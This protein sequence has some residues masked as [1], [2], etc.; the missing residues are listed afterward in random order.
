MFL[1]VHMLKRKILFQG[2][3]KKNQV[4]DT[5]GFVSMVPIVYF[6]PEAAASCCF[7]SLG[8][9]D[10]EIFINTRPHFNFLFWLLS[11]ANRFILE[12]NPQ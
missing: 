6:F 9:Q 10:C 11:G 8:R 12:E 3:K 5:S 2:K 1:F 7:I 4:Y